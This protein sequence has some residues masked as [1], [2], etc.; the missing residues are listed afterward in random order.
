MQNAK[1][2]R[3]KAESKRQKAKSKKQNA[4][5]KMQNAKCRMQKAESKRLKAK[6]N[7]QRSDEKFFIRSPESLHGC[8]GRQGRNMSTVGKAHCNKIIKK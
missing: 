1:G 8:S 3:Q 4:K 7:E 5:C 6:S 2:K